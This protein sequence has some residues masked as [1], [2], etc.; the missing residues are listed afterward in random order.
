MANKKF[1][2]ENS[3]S[4]NGHNVGSVAAFT[5]SCAHVITVWDAPL[6]VFIVSN[7]TIPIGTILPTLAVVAQF[8]GKSKKMKATLNSIPM[9]FFI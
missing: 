4:V 3:F 7:Y 6:T 2:G 8:I 1:Y 5:G 9:T